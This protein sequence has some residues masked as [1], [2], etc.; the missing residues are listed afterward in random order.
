VGYVGAAASIF[1]IALREPAVNNR[2]LR[3]QVSSDTCVKPAPGKSAFEGMLE[4]DRDGVVER[5]IIL[6]L[7]SRTPS[8]LQECVSLPALLGLTAESGFILLQRVV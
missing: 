5:K 4:L 3:C 6:Q 7:R 8:R 1:R 2:R